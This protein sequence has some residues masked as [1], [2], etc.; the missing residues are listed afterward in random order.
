MAAAVLLLPMLTS[1]N[2]PAAASVDLKPPTVVSVSPG[3]GAIG[4]VTSVRPTIVFSESIRPASVIDTF[5]TAAGANVPVTLDYVDSTRTLTF[6]PVSQ[7]T[8]GVKY[9]IRVWGVKDT[10]GNTM[11]TTKTWSFTVQAPPPPNQPPV[12]RIAVDPT[13]GLLPLPVTV[14]A[15]ASTDDVAVVSYAFD[16]GDGVTTG[17][18]TTAT[19]EHTY[20][21]AGTFTV[22]VTVSD[23]AG[24]TST[25]TT[26]V[27]ASTPPPPPNFAPVAALTVT[28]SSGYAPLGVTADASA[29]TDTDTFPIATYAF[30]FGDGSAV[31]GPQTAPTAPHTYTDLGSHT[32]TVTVTDTAGLSSTS[33]APVMVNAQPVPPV[34]SLSVSPNGAVA[35]VVVTLDAT[36]STGAGGALSYKFDFGDGTTAGPGVD[37]KVT[38]TYTAA[39][40]GTVQ[41][42]VV[43]QAGLSASA[44]ASLTVKPN[45]PAPTN[46]LPNPSVE[47]VRPANCAA[48]TGWTAGPCPASW[49]T[50]GHGGGTNTSTYTYENTG[51]TGTHSL[52]IHGTG[53]T[54]PY[55]PLVAHQGT[56][57]WSYAAIPAV[58]GAH[59]LYTDM[60]KATAASE[61]DASILMSD[62]TT[63]SYYLGSGQKSADW[64]PFHAEFDMPV[65]AVSVNVV[66]L[67]YQNG[68]LTIDDM[69]WGQYTPQPFSRGLV[70]VTLDDG[71]TDQ[72]TN[73]L[74]IM[75]AAGVKGT[76]YIISD[77][78]TN[79]PDYMTAAQVAALKADGQDIQSHTVHHLDLTTLTPDEVD[80][81]LKLS[82]QQLTSE[83]GGPV[84]DLATPFGTSNAETVAVASKYYQ[85]LRTTDRG[86]NERDSLDPYRLRVQP[87]DN[88]ATVAQVENWIAQAAYDR[89]WLILMY[90]H[91]EEPNTQD[92]PYYTTPADFAAEMNA[93]ANSGL[94][95]STLTQ[96]LHETAPQA[97]ITLNPVPPVS[98]EMI[99]NPSL[100][101]PT[102]A[103][104]GPANW[105]PDTWGT[106]T[107]TFSWSS[108]AHTGGKSARV[109]M[110]GWVDG[111]AKWYF[112][113]VPIHSGA[114][115][116]FSDWY[117]SNLPSTV[118]VAYTMADGTVY[119]DGE[120]FA[121]PPSATWT[122]YK[123]GV[124]FP[125]GAVQ[126]YF[127]HAIS[128]NGWLLTDDYSMK[129]STVDAGF[130]RPMISLSF[131]DGSPS[132]YAAIATV[133]SYSANTWKTTQFVPTEDVN[134]GGWTTAQIQSIRNRGHEIASHSVTHPDLTEVTPAQ[135]RTE[136]TA[137]KSTLEA[138]TGSGT[139]TDFATPYG[140]YN[141]TVLQA[142]HD[143]GYT[144]NRNVDNGYNTA[145]DLNPYNI[146][147]QN[148]MATTT[149]AEFNSWVN[150]AVAGRYWLVIVYHEV[151]DG[152]TGDTGED[153]YTV[154]PAMFAQQLASINASGIT[155]KTIKAA[156]TEL[157][158]QRVAW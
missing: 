107:P 75:D 73:G 42:T 78:L 112:P 11:T 130:T 54:D 119:Y 64:T 113:S 154:T 118:S 62:G 72:F 43:D 55:D 128:G 116:V 37:E 127:A 99:Y 60:Y 100:E 156:L 70:T 10:H 158:P 1:G 131:D 15:S 126:A 12:A 141:P 157:L 9:T 19:A 155:V 61:V 84:G 101:T 111:Q 94:A 2:N 80:L 39:F 69:F 148:M 106:N 77:D 105:L 133:D 117:K 147:V 93:V 23:I 51:S 33:S 97:G 13:S 4:V 121:I 17:P 63:K 122:Q 38:H 66:H 89:T 88:R 26:T 30:D 108:D 124:V 44:T 125:I 123:I 91:I 56:A 82:Q 132:I 6:T 150:E 16:F 137:S 59:Y 115:Y 149:L 140:A 52:T 92:Q 103:G 21:S 32:V 134:D 76:F 139:V 57:A 138:I 114:R 40:T 136:L 85:S 20:T 104:T 81:E 36:A 34:A 41:V 65:G 45:P 79:Q 7:L 152:S 3:D 98:D 25:A 142:I 48:T 71:T 90:H 135:L 22:K 109:D 68:D 110:S 87:V 120:D 35:P 24:L 18:Q 151:M 74:P 29:S 83:F 96:A 144:S 27:S 67:M 102:P 129:P 145:Y 31:V 50:A 14:N 46:L 49:F 53:F 58:G 86:Y 28:P 143:A 5:R 47:T 146:H 153:Q 95:V 8:Q